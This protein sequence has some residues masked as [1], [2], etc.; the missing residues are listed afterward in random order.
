MCKHSVV[1]CIEQIHALEWQMLL[2]SMIL[3]KHSSDFFYF[4]FTSYGYNI[5]GEEKTLVCHLWVNH[6]HIV[7]WWWKLQPQRAASGATHSQPCFFFFLCTAS[8]SF[9]AVVVFLS[10]IL[11][12]LKAAFQSLFFFT[13][14]LEKI[15]QFVSFLSPLFF[16]SVV[17]ARVFIRC[18]TFM[19]WRSPQLNMM[20]KK[21]QQ[22]KPAA[23]HKFMKSIKLQEENGTV[24]DRKNV[25]HLWAMQL[26]RP[27]F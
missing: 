12:L 26:F 2:I 20:E 1:K 8:N 10:L 16:L 25:T 27:F 15:R 9:I 11:I 14:L 19:K 3:M 6:C 22:K 13:S 7:G 18:S 5:H 21:K 23:I 4:F 24:S 17:S